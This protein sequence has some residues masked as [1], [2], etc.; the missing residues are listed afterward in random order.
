LRDGDTCVGVVA[1]TEKI[2]SRY[3]VIAAGSFC[4]EIENGASAGALSITRFAPTYPVRGQML[5]LRHPKIQLRRVLRSERAYLVPRLDG[6]LVAGSTLENVGF[7]KQVTSEGIHKILEGVRELVPALQDAEIIETWAG[8]R[9]GTS[10]GLPIIGITQM[11][12]LLIATGHYRNGVL[13]APATA[14][15]IRDLIVEGKTGMNIAAYSPLR[16]P[17]QP[18]ASGT[19]HSSVATD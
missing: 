3:V 11:N 10:D 8:L 9:P 2:A 6:R 15:I 16:F 17:Q 5:A 19:L 7:V 1:G 14:A 4:G 18:A 12:G 13:L